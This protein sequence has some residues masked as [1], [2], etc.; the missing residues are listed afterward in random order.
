MRRAWHINKSQ[1][2]RL[3]VRVLQLRADR[4]PSAAWTK[5]NK[6]HSI[7]KHQENFLLC[8]DVSFCISSPKIATVFLGLYIAPIPHFFR[9][10]L[11]VRQSSFCSAS[12]TVL[13]SF[14]RH[15][16]ATRWCFVLKPRRILVSLWRR[17]SYIQR[18]PTFTAQLASYFMISYIGTMYEMLGL[19]AEPPSPLSQPWEKVSVHKTK[20]E[21][22]SELWEMCLTSPDRNRQ[23]SWIQEASDSFTKHHNRL[24]RKLINL[25]HRLKILHLWSLKRLDASTS[26]WLG[27]GIL[28]SLHH[29]PREDVKYN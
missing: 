4:K 6:F 29:S 1:T 22:V 28:V 25:Y 24:I 15:N 18:M 16:L 12:S 2:F 5:I 11:K 3:H 10:I 20:R 23:S 7:L 17:P 14:I 9:F 27:C 21:T 19:L 8:C 26:P 13:L